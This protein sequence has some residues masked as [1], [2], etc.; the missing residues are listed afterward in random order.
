MCL[1]ST[2]VRWQLNIWII[3]NKMSEEFG[4]QNDVKVSAL[5]QGS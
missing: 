2:T 1:E 5:A 3:F 4:I